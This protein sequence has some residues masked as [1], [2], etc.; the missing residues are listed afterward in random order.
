MSSENIQ[1]QEISTILELIVEQSETILSYPDGQIPQIELDIARENIRKLYNNF[2]I[3]DKINALIIDRVTQNMVNEMIPQVK[4]KNE[5]VETIAEFNVFKEETTEVIKKQSEKKPESPKI[6]A[7]I[8]ESEEIENKVITPVMDEHIDASI[9]KEIP[10]PVEVQLTEPT[11]VEEQIMVA[12]EATIEPISVVPEVLPEPILETKASTKVPEPIEETISTK[13]PKQDKTQKVPTSSLFD[14]PTPSIADVYKDQKSTLHERIGSN[15]S[16][17]SLANKLQQKPIS[18]LVK[19]IGI[20]DKFLLIKEL[21][22]N[23]G[24]E[25]NEAIQL[26]NN[27]ST[28]MQAFD[29]LDVLK[30]KYN[31]DESSDASLKLFDLIRRKYQQ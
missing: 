23:N 21:F 1:K 4:V 18:D 31:W 12:S 26:L 28:I 30:N 25:Y 22:Q 19:S 11:V 2:T 9:E 17:N 7:E 27:F 15:R 6:E 5:V 13:P 20:N 29:Y 14:T 3:L 24:E 16:D 10:L 8:I